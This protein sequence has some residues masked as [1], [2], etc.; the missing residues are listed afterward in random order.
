MRVVDV[1]L[2]AIKVPRAFASIASVNHG[3]GEP[4][5]RSCPRYGPNNLT[6]FVEAV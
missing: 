2:S 1:G 5:P 4:I 3:D 6:S